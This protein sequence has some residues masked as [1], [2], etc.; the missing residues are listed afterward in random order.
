[1]K[2]L[3]A[4]IAALNLLMTPV[5][6]MEEELDIVPVDEIEVISEA[7]EPVVEEIEIS[8]LDELLLDESLES[9]DMEQEVLAPEAAYSN[10]SPK[11]EGIPFD[12]EHFPDPAFRAYLIN[13]VD[14]DTDGDG[15]L[16]E[17]ELSI[18]KIFN[19]A[20][21]DEC[22]E[23]KSLE[24]I[25]YFTALQMLDCECSQIIILDVSQNSRLYSLS[26]FSCKLE[27]L[28]L[29][30]NSDLNTIW[31]YD[32]NLTSLDVST[33]S[34]LENLQ[35]EENALTYLDLSHNPKLYL[36]DVSDNELT[37]LDL[38]KNTKLGAIFCENNRLTSLDLSTN[39]KLHCLWCQGNDIP[40]IDLS[41]CPELVELV[42]CHVFERSNG[43]IAFY[44]NK[45]D[46]G[47]YDPS[48]VIDEG[49]T[50][51]ANGKTLYDPNQLLLVRSEYAIIGVG[52]KYQVLSDDSTVFA[53]ECSFKSSNKKIATVN[54]EGVVKGIKAGKVTIAI[55]AYGETKKVTIEVKQKP[56]KI[57]MSAKSLVLGVGEERTLS[58]KLPSGQGAQIKWTSSK[59]SIVKAKSFQDDF[60]GIPEVKLTALKTG[61]VTITAKTYNGKKA[62]CKV[63]VLPAPTSITLPVSELT[64]GVGQK[65]SLKPKFS[66]SDAGGGVSYI[67]SGH[68]VDIISWNNIGDITGK[69]PGSTKMTVETYNGLSASVD[70][71]VKAAP[72]TVTIPQKRITLRVG[73]TYQLQPEVPEGSYS[74]F[75][76]KSSNKKVAKVSSTGMIT[77]KRAGTARIT[78]STYNGKKVTCLVTVKK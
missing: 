4:V 12:E 69:K 47:A 61:T 19:I 59:K 37:S 1:M 3:I 32:N 58:A 63:R 62:T 54:S 45:S 24:G 18:P 77:A 65:Y 15:Y 36:L 9:P 57:K 27:E 52:E 68:D 39:K 17:A 33:C 41:G 46:I 76:Y 14:P 26:A 64:L 23:I 53:E 35:C 30:K 51:Y 71:T 38:G 25:Q 78:V 43:K 42:K 28:R 73:E 75:T 8:L 21:C 44:R 40:Y 7:L 20:V 70:I 66:P 48:V 10:D 49:T 6:M 11:G 60:I 55:S 34:K 13:H 16:S 5:A 31:V 72:T 2:K 29:S 22:G 74:P 67:Y 56:T 50:L